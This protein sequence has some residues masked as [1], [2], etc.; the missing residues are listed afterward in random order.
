MNPTSALSSL[1]TRAGHFC[2]RA[3]AFAQTPHKIIDVRCERSVNNSQLVGKPYL[4]GLWK[5][6]PSSRNNRDPFPKPT[7]GQRR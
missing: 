1:Q 5:V 3:W 6:C 7:S 4:I 2:R